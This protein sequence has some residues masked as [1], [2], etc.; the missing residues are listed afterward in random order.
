MINRAYYAV[1]Y[2]ILALFLHGDIRAKT[3]KHSGVITVFDRDFVPTGKI[4]KHYS[5]I[6]HRMFDARQQSDYKGPVEFSIGMLKT[7]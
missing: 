2:A 3:S 1:F 6:L 7:M 5:K 4:G